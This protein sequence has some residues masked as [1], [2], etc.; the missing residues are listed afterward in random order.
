MALASVLGIGVLLH[1]SNSAGADREAMRR[2]A[3]RVEALETRMASGRAELLAPAMPGMAQV[4]TPPS[5]P[6]P[7]QDASSAFN[8]SAQSEAL[9]QA[10]QRE[11][12]RSFAAQAPAPASDSTPQQVI[13]AF[14]SDEVLQALDVPKS[15]NVSCRANMCLIRAT[16]P[17]GADSSDWSTRVML[18]LGAA[19]PSYSTGYV[20]QPDGGYELQLYA[21]RP[22]R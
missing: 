1:R 10:R 2:L 14:G 17:L 6:S 19:L 18:E 15:Q 16:F 9:G 20:R 5:R 21:A 3:E 12:Q 13:A 22:R 8:G 4:N 7:E 11:L